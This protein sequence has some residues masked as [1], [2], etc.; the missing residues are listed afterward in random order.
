M[1]EVLLFVLLFSSPTL[2]LSLRKGSPTTLDLVIWSTRKAPLDPAQQAEL[3]LTIAV[4][5]ATE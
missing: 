5:D 1:T 2:D 4:A 3:S